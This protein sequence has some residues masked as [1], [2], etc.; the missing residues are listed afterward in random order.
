MERRVIRDRAIVVE[1]SEAIQYGILTRHR[2]GLLRQGLQ[3][4]SCEWFT[5]EIVGIRNV[6]YVVIR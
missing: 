4:R 5:L 1:R 6:Y 2:T 3:R